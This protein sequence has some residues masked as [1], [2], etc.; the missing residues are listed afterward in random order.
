M[1]RRIVLTAK[2][3]HQLD[4]LRADAPGRAKGGIVVVHFVFG[5]TD[6]IGEV[7]DDFAAQGYD[8]VAPCLY[9]RVG[10]NL[11]YPYGDEG[12][13]AGHKVYL[14]IAE[15][16]EAIVADVAAAVDA[17]KPSG[18]V[19]VSGFCLGGTWT[20]VA[21]AQLSIDA[22]VAFYGSH[23]PAFLQYSPRVPTQLHYGDS[24]PV[25]PMHDIE[26][27]R[28]ACPSVP[29]H[30]YPG[31]GHGFYNPNLKSYNPAAATLVR[32]RALAFLQMHI[33]G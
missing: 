2:D 20:W 18:K 13:M 3:G 30:I 28:K 32:E 7:C 31:C 16:P 1:A 12:A 17:V 22:A 25:V 33:A 21:A 6:H 23:I 15:H 14:Q 19:A 11:L 5:L 26:K 8:A 24:D 9:D 4:A 27:I 29:I 10:R